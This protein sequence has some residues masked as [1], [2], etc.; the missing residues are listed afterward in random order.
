MAQGAPSMQDT[1]NEILAK[2]TALDARMESLE[3]RQDRHE[4]ALKLHLERIETTVNSF[5]ARVQLVEKEVKTLTSQFEQHKIYM[6]SYSMRN[7][8]ILQGPGLPQEQLREDF[9]ATKAVVEKLFSDKG[10]PLGEI[11]RTHRMGRSMDG[12]PRRIVVRFLRWGDKDACLKR[13][14]KEKLRD[15]G[16]YVKS[17]QPHEIVLLQQQLREAAQRKWKNLGDGSNGT[18]KI[19]PNFDHIKVMGQKF[20]LGEDGEL[21][22]R[23][24]PR[25][26]QK[27]I[28]SP[29]ASALPDE[30]RIRQRPRFNID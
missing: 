29:E 19:I 5:G 10:L 7:N 3:R 20:Y 9:Y 15:A 13:E 22:Q 1:L 11:D 27:R 16:I 18:V 30:L 24:P 17:Q 23:Y 14:T 28:L 8:I 6:E 4:D 26:G 2:M 21:V 25:G 12:R